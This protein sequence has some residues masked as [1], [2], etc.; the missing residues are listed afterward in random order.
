MTQMPSLVDDV[1]KPCDLR[2]VYPDAASPELFERV[3]GAIGTMLA[4]GS[5]VLIA[6]DYRLSTSALKAAL[7]QGLV[8]AGVHLLDAGQGPTPLAYFA[9]RQLRADAVL[10]IT[11]SHNP[12]CYNGLKIMLG[13]IP[14]TPAQMTEIRELAESGMFR[15]DE[16]RLE[17]VDLRPVYLKTMLTKWKS[18]QGKPKRRVVIDAGNGAWSEMAPLIFRDLGFETVCISCNI[19]GRFPDR[20]PDCARAANL[21]GLRAAVRRHPNAVGV[22]W[23]GDGDR[24][25]FVD[26][27]GEYVTQDEIAILFARSALKA[28]D[29]QTGG[30]IVIDI[31]CSDAVRRA[32]LDAGGEPLIE[33]TGHAF[34]RGR[35]VVE[36]ALLGLDAC[37]HYFFRELNGGDDGL[38]AALY[39]LNLMRR[40]GASL[41]ELRKTLPSIYSTP[42][43]RVPTSELSFAEAKRALLGAF[44]TAETTDFD[45]LRLI[46][47]DGV[48][49]IR[50]SGTEPVLSL[51][52][53][54][55]D[56]SSYQHIL[57]QTTTFVPRLTEFLR[58][59]WDPAIPA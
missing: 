26:E 39:F 12:A 15:K 22:A 11:A 38:Y 57:R 1:W 17:N 24:V 10:M 14:M 51:R 19:D 16:G 32:V 42:E 34:M 18:L 43:L 20:S 13:A 54:G 5:R 45:G 53:E 44:P 55:F 33:R 47:A 25:A 9:G 6:G 37:G 40:N 4:P 35:M 30:K 21:G 2:G 31:K 41:R 27:D 46:L 58:Q 50:E 48:V 52:I 56:Q 23:D 7:G 36:D 49:L 8:R 29:S 3:G 59:E 28:I